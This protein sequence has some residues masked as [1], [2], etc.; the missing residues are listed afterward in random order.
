MNNSREVFSEHLSELTLNLPLDELLYNANRVESAVYVNVLKWVGLENE[1][2]SL[3]LGN[4]QDNVRVELELR[5][6]KYHRHHKS[7]FSCEHSSR[8]C[9]VVNVGLLVVQ[10]I[11]LCCCVSYRLC[12]CETGTR[13]WTLV[14]STKCASPV[15]VK[16]KIP[17]N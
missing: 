17:R 7:L 12:I 16:R 13:T 1:G 5:K 2:D 4:Y 10:R 6:S 9:H 11:C 3:L 14:L 8:A 15:Y